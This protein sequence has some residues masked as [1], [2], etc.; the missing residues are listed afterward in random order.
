MH[1]I[2][3]SNNGQT[4]NATGTNTILHFFAYCTTTK[5]CIVPE[6]EP[7]QFVPCPR[8]H[9][10]HQLHHPNTRACARPVQGQLVLPN[11]VL[12][13]TLP[14]LKKKMALKY[15]DAN[16]SPVSWHINSVPPLIQTDFF[17]PR[18]RNVGAAPG[19]TLYSPKYQLHCP[20]MSPGEQSELELRTSLTDP[21]IQPGYA[22]LSAYGQSHISSFLCYIGDRAM[23]DHIK[24][25][26]EFGGSRE[27]V[28][29]DDGETIDEWTHSPVCPLI[30]PL[31]SDNSLLITLL[32]LHM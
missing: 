7:D 10:N 1:A 15:E 16:F 30:R 28:L 23:A 3:A 4:S 29:R 12:R 26:W 20:L 9:C 6:P 14:D 22:I 17:F 31:S 27:R 24:F 18:T 13:Q 5:R 11:P 32:L 25:C 8:C 19:I 2:P 21:A